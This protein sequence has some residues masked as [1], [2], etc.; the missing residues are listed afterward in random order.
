M[1]AEL[2]LTWHSTGL[3]Y[4]ITYYT[5]GWPLGIRL[6]RGLVLDM[7]HTEVCML[8]RSATVTVFWLR[9]VINTIYSILRLFL[10]PTSIRLYKQ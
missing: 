1:S 5:S 3:L 8:L 10:D 2:A 6:S 4:Y 9:D 7:T